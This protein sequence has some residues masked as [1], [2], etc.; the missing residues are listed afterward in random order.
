MRTQKTIS[1]GMLSKQICWRISFPFFVLQQVVC[2]W[3]YLSDPSRDCFQPACCQPRAKQV[4][5]GRADIITWRGKQDPS[6][7][8]LG[9]TWGLAAN[10]P[11]SFPS[12]T[13]LQRKRPWLFGH[14]AFYRAHGRS[15]LSARLLWKSGFGIVTGRERERC[16]RLL[17][18]P[19]PAV[20]VSRQGWFSFPGG[21]EKEADP[22]VLW[23]ARKGTASCVSSLCPQATDWAGKGISPAQ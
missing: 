14:S 3:A 4:A 1:S 6:R 9:G 19:A 5:F 22:C 20:L 12:L 18:P 17:K 21:R 16:C 8:L 10:G 11:Q 2:A 23:T 15:A 13:Q 7:H